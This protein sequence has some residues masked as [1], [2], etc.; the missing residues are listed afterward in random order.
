[1]QGLLMKPPLVL[2]AAVLLLCNLHLHAGEGEQQ[3]VLASQQ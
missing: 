2:P 3:Q 1:M